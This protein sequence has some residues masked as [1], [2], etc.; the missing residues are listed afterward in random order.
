MHAHALASQR[1]ETTKQEKG[2]PWLPKQKANDR[3]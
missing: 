2:N 3:G 1:N